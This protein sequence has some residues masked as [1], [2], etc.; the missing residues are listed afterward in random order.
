MELKEIATLGSYGVNGAPN[1]SL[2]GFHY[3]A[4]RQGSNT[5][6]N[7]PTNKHGMTSQAKKIFLVLSALDLYFASE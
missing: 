2:S 5:L 1:N 6:E 7:V 4:N 3:F